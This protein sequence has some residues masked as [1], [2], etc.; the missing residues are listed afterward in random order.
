MSYAAEINRLSRAFQGVDGPW[1]SAFA[2][3]ALTARRW[4]WA[5]LCAGVAGACLGAGLKV[6]LPSSYVATEQL[7]FDP[8]GV[9]IFS[10]DLTVTNTDP[11]AAIAAVESQMEV[12]R[13]ERVLSRVVD[14]E[15]AADEGKR[16]QAGAIEDATEFAFE[17]FCPTG[18][19]GDYAKALQ[20][21]FRGLAVSRAER[22]YVVD[23]TATE[24]SPE[25][26]ARLARNLVTAYLE[27]DAATRTA[28]ANA[29]TTS[30]AG[31][32]ESLRKALHDSEDRSE[33]YRRDY[34]LVRIGDKLLVEQQLAAA[35]AALAESR[36]RLDHARARV[37]QLEN[38]PS[39]AS[40]LSAFGPDA[41]TRNLAVLTERRDAASVEV[42]ALAGRLGAKNPALQEARSRLAEIE[43]GLAVELTAI[44]AAAVSDL[45]RAT[46]EDANLEATVA[47]LSKQVENARQAEIQ[48]GTLQQEVDANR[49]LLDSFETRSREASEFGRLDSGNL[50]IVSVARAPLVQGKRLK[51][52]VWAAVGFVVAILLTIAGVTMGA[53]LKSGAAGRRGIPEA[54]A[55]IEDDVASRSS[56]SRRRF[57]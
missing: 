36:S 1:P 11:N 18:P 29:L 56:K 44:R 26:A 17:L 24:S 6:L 28:T 43:K 51:I 35:S 2:S 42:A 39:W 22:S 14:R 46:N 41:D 4:R 45:T 25:L 40:A 5:I 27:E 12:L 9:K 57:A 38:A 10:A 20:I 13:S 33:A 23:V 16:A 19:G 50:R 32:L 54:E 52:L 15:C 31:R 34:K 49:K 37:K 30:L 3:L 48:L 8:H 7:L 47:T 21:L 53:L 55:I